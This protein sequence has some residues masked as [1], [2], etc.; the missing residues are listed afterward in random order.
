MPGV[1]TQMIVIFQ[2]EPFKIARNPLP[3]IDRVICL[4]SGVEEMDERTLVN[5]SDISELD[6]NLIV[7]WRGIPNWHAK[8]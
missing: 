7:E 6:S 8:P 4:L 5:E 3:T 1:S 2:R